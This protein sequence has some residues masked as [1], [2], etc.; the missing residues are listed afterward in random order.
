MSWG[1]DGNKLAFRRLL[2]SNTLRTFSLSL[3]TVFFPI[4]LL[5]HGFSIK[6]VLLYFL[7]YA[8]LGIFLVYPLFVFISKI[9]IKKAFIFSYIFSIPIYL[10]LYFVDFFVLEFGMI[11]F[12]GLLLFF[13]KFG[14]SVYWYSYHLLFSESSSRKHLGKNLGKIE[15]FSQAVVLMSPFLGGILITFFSYTA[16]FVIIMIFLTL[17]FIPL[18]LIKCPDIPFNVKSKDVF[19]SNFFWR[20]KV[21]FIEGFYDS[22]NGL[23]WPIYLYFLKFKIIVL[24]LFVTMI[25]LVGSIVTYFLGHYIGKDVERDNYVSRLGLFFVGVGVSLRGF[26]SHVYTLFAAQSISALGAPFFYMPVIGDMYKRSEENPVLAIIGRELFLNIGRMVLLSI[27]LAFVLIF[28]INN[29]YLL[30]VILG[31]LLVVPSLLRNF[32]MVYS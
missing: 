32:S 7:V 28:D 27:T 31:L 18:F 29:F 3:F 22:I 14:E 15:S 24:G 21:Y 8:T 17:A 4:F 11:L 6:Y 13:N 16:V 2:I 1:K 30:F 26:F 20:N 10:M 5:T 9:G 23:I 19:C 12:L 25:N